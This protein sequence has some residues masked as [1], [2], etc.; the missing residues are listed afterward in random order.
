MFGMSY[1]FSLSWNWYESSC[2]HVQTHTHTDGHTCGYEWDY[3]RELND[4]F[5]AWEEIRFAIAATRGLLIIIREWKLLILRVACP[6][7]YI[8]KSVWNCHEFSCNHVHVHKWPYLRQWVKILS[9]KSEVSV[10]VFEM[11]RIWVFKSLLIDRAWNDINVC[12]MFGMSST[13]CVQKL[14]WILL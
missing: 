14:I 2:N 4:E 9:V 12:P 3:G 7:I 11:R 10:S 8:L 13:F 1:T 5:L 6:P